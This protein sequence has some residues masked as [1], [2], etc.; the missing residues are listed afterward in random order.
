MNK[1]EFAAE[2]ERLLQD[3]P[4]E[5]RK[6]SVDFY[7][8]MIDDRMEDGESEEAA[9]AWLGSPR[10]VADGIMENAA[11][12]ISR[13][14]KIDPWMIVL[15]V[16]ASPIWLPIL[17]SAAAVVLSLFVSV[18]SVILSFAAA[19]I[20]IAAGAVGGA[21]VSAVMFVTQPFADAV[22]ILGCSIML[23]GVAIFG[24]YASERLI[25][26]SAKGTARLFKWSVSA[27]GAAGR[28]R[29]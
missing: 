19:A 28:R 25:V 16:M 13:R 10:S 7:S 1:I 20:G 2:L 14:R 29:A 17:V 23:A 6:R 5:E 9:V 3:L 21:A 22:F 27:V 24:V 8:E 26:L 12:N 15:A 11:G 4:E 18:W